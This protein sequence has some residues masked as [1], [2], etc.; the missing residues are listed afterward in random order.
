MTGMKQRENFSPQEAKRLNATLFTLAKSSAIPIVDPST[1]PGFGSEDGALQ[2]SRV[3]SKTTIGKGSGAQ[4]VHDS[5]AAAECHGAP[6]TSNHSR[7]NSTV[8]PISTANVNNP[9]DLSFPALPKKQ[10]F[11]SARF[12]RTATSSPEKSG[13]SSKPQLPNRP[14]PLP[15][16]STEMRREPSETEAKN[17]KPDVYARTYVPESFL[18]VNMSPAVFLPS[19]PIDGINF[20]KYISTFAGSHFLAPNPMI[21]PTLLETPSG[22]HI[23]RQ[24]DNLSPEAYLDYFQK[25][26]QLELESQVFE[27]RHYDMFG[28][29]LGY[30]T[31]N[32]R[33]Y[34]LVVPGLRESTP[35]IVLGNS[36]MLRQLRL[37]PATMLPLAMNMWMAPG[38]GQQRGEPAPGFTGCQHCAVVWGIDKAKEMLLLRIDG[39]V[40][41]SMLFNVSFVAQLDS[42]QALQR[43]IILVS[44]ILGEVTISSGL[45][46]SG[47]AGQREVSATP[48]LSK[49]RQD[50]T[51]ILITPSDSAESPASS[52]QRLVRTPDNESQWMRRILFPIESDG[53]L[54]IR[55]P[56]GHFSQDWYD[57][58]LNYEQ[59]KAVDTIQHA[60]YGS[61]PFLISGPPGTGKTKTIV[62]T[63]LQLINS[64]PKC[65]HIL[66]CAPSDPAADTLALR[67][68][69]HLEP[70]ELFR[71]N[72]SSRT[73][74]E[75]P[76]ELLP[77][78][79]TENDLFTLPVFT[80]LMAFRIIVTTCRD[81]DILVQAR[82]TNR[83]L[84]KLEHDLIQ[85]IHPRSSESTS[86]GPLISLHWSALLIDEAAQATEPEACIPLTVVAPPPAETPSTTPYLVMAG[87][88]HQLGPRLSSRETALSTSLFERLLNRPMYKD[89]PQSRKHLLHP[90]PHPI[91]RAI[92]PPFATL[93]RNYRSHPSILAVPSAL[94]YADTL[95]PEAPSTSPLSPWPG[96]LGR[97]WPVLFACNAGA[98]E[99]EQEAGGWYNVSEALKACS[100][101][102]SLVQTSLIAQ[103]D[104][105]IMSPFRA[106]VNL[107]RQMM[108]KEPFGMYGVNIGPME[109]FQ[110]L[111]SRVV[112]V[113]TT[114][115][116][117]RFL[118]EDHKR[119]LGIIGEAKRFNVALTRARDG[120]VV[121]GNPWILERDPSWLAFLGFCYR[122]GL[123]E[124]DR[125]ATSATTAQGR[126]PSAA[127]SASGATE[128]KHVNAWAPPMTASTPGPPAYISR[129]ETALVYRDREPGRYSSATERFM[130]TR[131]D[132]AMWVSGLAAEEVLREL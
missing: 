35:R 17:W 105:C 37:D 89:H 38:G 40:P 39:L 82:V 93:I 84:A 74:A 49:L 77:Y 96:W 61:L 34:S 109:A 94:F 99:I 48:S 33:T 51:K 81:A 113:C 27:H 41:E 2:S 5:I 79:C 45:V 25:C 76:G 43:A 125:A 59:M 126:R 130:N 106:Q 15:D 1:R 75:V 31:L 22:N 108:R 13:M 131:E 56:H 97:G 72:A 32:D 14:G 58:Q 111:E 119:G 122:H 69:H 98:D 70:S 66:L 16:N 129:L 26:L 71:L 57:T 68:R 78:C 63:A 115:T 7:T 101:A 121:I 28:V 6:K 50:F 86:P 19:K 100:Y 12:P 117:G 85:A 4:A 30:H 83:D 64:S 128:E 95:I 120:L 103:E 54:Q 36:V 8:Q 80:I 10:D 20:P 23:S 46:Q 114:R 9:Y 73:F 123:W 110:G 124:G 67:L 87:D 127:G 118:D 102:R 104:I 29:R 132:D 88:E 53:V 116:R 107:L 3:P 92:Q 55:L 62:E 47:D 90:S 112:I 18:A 91:T 11:F 52:R 44:A 60:R 65:S 24:P 42:I 21:P